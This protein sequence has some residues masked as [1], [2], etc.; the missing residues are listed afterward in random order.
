MK[1]RIIPAIVSVILIFLMLFTPVLAKDN[2]N[3]NQGLPFQELWDAVEELQQQIEDAIENL[4]LDMEDLMNEVQ[5]YIDTQFADIEPLIEEMVEDALADLQEQLDGIDEAVGQLQ[6]DLSN[7]E[8]D[9]INNVPAGF[10]DGIDN[11]GIDTE[12]D[13][14]FGSSDA[15]DIT[16]SDIGNWNESH[17]WG[18]HSEAGYL[19][20][21]P[22]AAMLE[23]EDI[24]LLANDAGYLSSESDPTVP[25]NLKDGVSWN[26]INGIPS[27]FA[28]GT[29]DVG[30][31]GSLKHLVNNF[32]VASGHSV[33]AG[34][35][36][37]F[38]DGFIQK[39][40]FHGD[41]IAFSSGYT[42]NPA[43]TRGMSAAALS[44]TQFVVVYKDWDNF[45]FN[46]AIVGEV[47]GNTITYGSES[48]FCSSG[49][50]FDNLAP[51]IASLSPTKF[52]VAY[53]DPGNSD[54]GT[55]RIGT[56][57][58]TDISFGSTYVFNDN[59][60]YSDT[61]SVSALSEDSFVIAYRD[62]GNSS[63]GTAIIGAVSDSD[64][65][66]GSE[67]VYNPA[68][69]MYNKV[70]ALSET[71]IVVAYQDGGGSPFSGTAIIGEVSGDTITFGT[72]YEFNADGTDYIS[73]AALSESQFV[74]AYED[75]G[76]SSYGTAIIGGVSGNTITF[77]T[78]AVFNTASPWYISVTTMSP[79]KFVIAYSDTGNS[80]Y[81]TAILG[82]VSGNSIVFGSEYSFNSADTRYISATTLSEKQFV[83]VYM[84]P[85]SSYTFHGIARIGDI[86]N[87]GKVIGIAKTEAGEGEAVPVIIIGVSDVHSGLVTGETYFANTAGD[88]TT[89]V[90]DYRI[91]F[92]ISESE[93]FL[94]IPAP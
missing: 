94:S 20:E 73:A 80:D 32:V 34:D 65:T 93:L 33:A 36:V 63:Y 66:F 45:Y 29:D 38:L 13:P 35:V 57:T 85:G 24:S 40:H 16:S 5:D 81:G 44:D 69:S 31:G 8:W 37:T 46:T 50:S 90:T 39:G 75:D 14:V 83:V 25:E 2:E 67:Y 71:K 59:T 62:S 77:G 68:S 91:G 6:A 19:T 43:S 10:A 84:H 86:A 64:I 74:V 92:A 61:L 21:I 11:V 26:E 47:T 87:W 70:V 56:V 78:E 49:S 53:Q 60:T 54:Y 15:S 27:G 51:K 18:D 4:H 48:V 30:A 41:E 76:N 55:A 88:L 23:G 42:Y 72:E 9:D 17:S 7:I 79:E 22:S 52:V 1:H 28:D 3:G 12:T 82:D 89:S 58:G